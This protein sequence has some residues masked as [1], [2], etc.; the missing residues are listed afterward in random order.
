MRSRPGRPSVAQRHKPNAVTPCQIGGVYPARSG[1]LKAL[2]GAM[3]RGV[4]PVNHNA[5]AARRLELL[6]VARNQALERDR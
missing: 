5:G 2:L 1:R 3:K 6:A 4:L